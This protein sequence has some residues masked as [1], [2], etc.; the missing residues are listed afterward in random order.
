MEYLNPGGTSKDRIAASMISEAEASGALKPGGTVVEG[1]SGSTG[2]CLASLC[3][4]KGY[5]CTIVMPDDQVR[6][7]VVCHSV[8]E[9]FGLFRS[10]S[11]Q[12]ARVLGQLVAS[13][14]SSESESQ[15]RLHVLVSRHAYEVRQG[16]IQVEGR[17]GEVDVSIA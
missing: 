2:I 13:K 5:R 15:P 6:F 9:A 3:R 8:L 12:D 7:P 4:A 10:I 14:A 17:P 16:C 1:T 11:G